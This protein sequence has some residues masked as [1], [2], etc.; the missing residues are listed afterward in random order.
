M[1]EIAV[2]LMLLVGAGLMI[3]SFRS[4]TAVEPG[5][6]PH[7]LLTI[8]TPLQQSTYKDQQLQLQFYERALPALCA[9]PGVQSA[10]GVFRLPITGFATAIFTESGKSWLIGTYMA[11]ANVV[12]LGCLMLLRKRPAWQVKAEEEAASAAPARGDG[13]D[14]VR[15]AEPMEIGGRTIQVAAI[16]D[17]IRMKLVAGRPKDRIEAEIL[18][19]VREAIESEKGEG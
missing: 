12:A 19:A 18:G 9:L 16:Q 4:A 2:A 13:R 1:I 10:A 7:N 3:R 6:D 11:A 5:F 17:L 8:A 14:L 15:T